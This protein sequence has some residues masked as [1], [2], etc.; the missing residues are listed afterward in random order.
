MADRPTVGE[1]VVTVLRRSVASWQ[2]ADVWFALAAYLAILLLPISVTGLLEDFLGE[3]VSK[4]IALLAMG[5]L[6]V[7]FLVITPFRMWQEERYR[8]NLVEEAGQP[9]IH[10]AWRFR[11]PHAELIIKNQSAKTITGIEVMFRNYRNADG[12]K[13]YE[14]LK[15]LVSNDGKQ[16]PIDLNPLVPM[17]FRF[18]E[19]GYSGGSG[20]IMVMPGTALSMISIPS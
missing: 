2:G 18:A 15:S 5:W 7:L 13:I 11:D 17:Y 14:V 4:T 1:Y 3:W 12:S 16:A 9:K 6:A 10:V 8:M 20:T 19:L